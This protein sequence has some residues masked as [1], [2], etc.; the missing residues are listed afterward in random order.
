MSLIVLR[1]KLKDFLEVRNRA[2]TQA[3]NRMQNLAHA[4]IS[5]DRIGVQFQS[6]LEVLGCLFVLA[7]IS[8]QSC[9]MNTCAEVLLVND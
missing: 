3:C 6:V 5:R 1:I 4:E 8:K 7:R 2:A 9:K